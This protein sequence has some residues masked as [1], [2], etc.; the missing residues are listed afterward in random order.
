MP[1]ALE[2]VNY[3]STLLFDAAHLLKN[4]SDVSSSNNDRQLFD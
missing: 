4:E 3:A 2:R 1:Q